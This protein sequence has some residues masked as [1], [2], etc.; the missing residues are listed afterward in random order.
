MK[1]LAAIDIGACVAI[2]YHF[3]ISS[4][5]VS[6]KAHT[7]L[8]QAKEMPETTLRINTVC[9][10]QAMKI[11][12]TII[13]IPNILSRGYSENFLRRQSEAATGGVL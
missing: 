1:I 7:F 2:G 5:S 9:N 8:L 11:E 12:Q 3:A 10:F 13:E 4:R 6:T